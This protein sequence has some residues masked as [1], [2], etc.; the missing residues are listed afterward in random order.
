MLVKWI[1]LILAQ[2][3][4]KHIMVPFYRYRND[5]SERLRD[6]PKDI[7]LVNARNGDGVQFCL[8]QLRGGLPLPHPDP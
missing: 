8:S 3:T 2:S 6:L 4:E 5:G 7:Q 1:L